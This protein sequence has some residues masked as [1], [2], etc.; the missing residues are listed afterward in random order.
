M[1]GNSFNKRLNKDNITAINTNNRKTKPNMAPNEIVTEEWVYSI[2][3]ILC[4]AVVKLLKAGGT[5]KQTT[6]S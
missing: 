2:D 5:F 1:I 3:L 4:Q 6:L